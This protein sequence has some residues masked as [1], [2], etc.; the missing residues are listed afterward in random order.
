MFPNMYS[1]SFQDRIWETEIKLKFLQNFVV[2]VHFSIKY[3]ALELF[4]S[5]L[6][7]GCKDSAECYPALSSSFTFNGIILPQYMCQD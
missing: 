6:Q 2:I 3:F 4:F 7:I 5:G 1:L